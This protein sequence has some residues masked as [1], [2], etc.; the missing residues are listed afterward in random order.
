MGNDSSIVKQSDRIIYKNKDNKIHRD[1]DLPAIEY[2]NGDL[3]WCFNDEIHR[4]VKNSEGMSLPAI[5]TKERKLWIKNN[6]LFREKDL[7]AIE[8]VNGDLAW[9]TAEINV[10]YLYMYS[11]LPYPIIRYNRI[12]K[13]SEGNTLP[14]FIGH[15][16]TKKWY[17]NGKLHREA[18][19]PAV[20]ESN[21]TQ[22]WYVGGDL[23]RLN[24]MPAVIKADGTQEWYV[25]G[26]SYRHGDLPHGINTKTGVKYWMD[27][28][29]RKTILVYPNGDKEYYKNGYLV[30]TEKAN[31]NSLDKYVQ[32]EEG[33]NTMI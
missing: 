18:D 11:A 26:E 20:I 14:A 6:R 10:G 8:Y 3:V 28:Y 9:V 1:H 33:S 4:D 15:D 31:S 21:G 16:G 24:D 5:I 32:A 17:L 2:K 22:E 30:Y 29:K 27:K 23:H 19:L 7:P 12:T 25:A 13:D